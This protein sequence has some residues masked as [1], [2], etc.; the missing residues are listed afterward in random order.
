MNPAPASAGSSSSP[1]APSAP[2]NG[3]TQTGSAQPSQSRPPL[4]PLNTAFAAQFLSAWSDFS[5]GLFVRDR[6]KFEEYCSDVLKVA[7]K[8]GA[9]VPEEAYTT[10]HVEQA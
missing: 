10:T 7:A 2:V 8:A 3:S 4:P 5:S 6:E 1:T 9:K